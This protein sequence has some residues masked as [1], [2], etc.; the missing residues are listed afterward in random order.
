MTDVYN[1][2]TTADPA[3]VERI[4]NAL[5]LRAADPKQ[6]EMLDSYLAE[7]NFPPNAL[8][9]EVGCGTGPISRRLVKWQNVAQVIG[10]DPSPVFVEKAQALSAAYPNL[11]FREAYAH[12][13]P[14]SNEEFDAVVFHT[15]LCH[16]SK[17]QEALSEAF[18]VLKQGGWLAAFDGDYASTTFGTGDL[19]HYKSARIHFGPTLSMTVGSR[20]LHPNWLRQRDS[21]CR[22]TRATAIRKPPSPIIC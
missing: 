14:F 16:L 3:M 5:E 6:K 1:T 7:I 17:P 15:T 22:V 12:P 20:G 8:V 19:T 2:I 18:R 13:L 11:S 21:L 4:A 10:V 9:L